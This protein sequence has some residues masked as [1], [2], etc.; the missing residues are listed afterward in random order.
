MDNILF[1]T[2]DPNMLRAEK[3]AFSSRFKMEDQGEAHFSLGMQTTRDR[4]NKILCV[5]Q[6]AYLEN[7][8]KRF[9]M[10]DCKS[11]ATP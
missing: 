11:V 10:Y 9:G 4:K 6:K 5:N 3:M 8:L 1:A 2:N 7:M